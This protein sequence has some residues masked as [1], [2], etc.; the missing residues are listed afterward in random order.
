MRS[1]W[2][3]LACAA[4]GEP[5]RATTVQYG[6]ER[7]VSLA[8]SAQGTCVLTTKCAGVDTSAFEFSFLCV[9][10]KG[11]EVKHTFGDGGF[12]SEEDYDTEVS[13][14]ECA[15]PDGQVAAKTPEKTPEATEAK[16]K[17]AAK[18]HTIEKVEASEASTEST[19][20]E[21]S[22]ASEADPKSPPATLAASH[23]LLTKFAASKAG[24]PDGVPPAHASFYGPGGC[25]ATF[26]SPE[27]TCVMQTR[28]GGQ[29]ISAYEFG[30]SCVDSEGE[31]TQH[32]FGKNSFDREET[33][34]TLVECQRCLGLDDK[35]PGQLRDLASSVQTLQSEMKA[36]V[37]SVEA[38]KKHLDEKADEQA[39]PTEE[40]SEDAGA[41]EEAAEEP[42]DAEDTEAAQA[43]A[44]E[45][46]DVDAAAEEAAEEAAGFLRRSR[47][48]R[49]VKRARPAVR[50]V[51]H[52]E[53][54]ARRHHKVQQEDDADFSIPEVT[55]Y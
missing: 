2:L 29:N 18:P 9:D 36:I 22:E 55:D 24:S 19:E 21:A 5:E 12:L 48:H 50:H 4:L 28:C 41:T 17:E 25:V 6:P 1:R 23:A 54:R 11:T 37:A 32:L 33:F 30:L 16:P 46:S 14:A 38:I 49:Q 10:D 47:K 40:A 8:R 20:S 42:D 15:A 51:R 45:A 13:C 31:T 53:R 35:A 39:A 44:D 27:G 43:A 34:D 52:H 3:L 26:R 7:C